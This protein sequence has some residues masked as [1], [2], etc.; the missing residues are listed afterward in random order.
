MYSLVRLVELV[1]ELRIGG[2]LVLEKLVVVRRFDC[3]PQRSGV[4]SRTVVHAVLCRAVV[5]AVR[6]RASVHA[7]LCRTV[8]PLASIVLLLRLVHAVGLVLGV[9]VAR[10]VG[11]RVHHSRPC[12]PVTRLAWPGLNN[13]SIT[14]FKLELHTLHD[15]RSFVADPDTVLLRLVFS[16]VF[17]PQLGQF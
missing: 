4:R 9:L 6:C 11:L 10:R 2:I 17:D 5:H 12:T 15:I 14:S 7:V 1:V 8:V 3:V 16:L 13:A